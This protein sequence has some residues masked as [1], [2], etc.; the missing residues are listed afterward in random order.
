MAWWGRY[1]LGGE[2]SVG[3]SGERNVVR[4]GI[5]NAVF[6]VVCVC[7]DGG[8]ME[9]GVTELECSCSVKTAAGRL[10]CCA[11]AEWRQMSSKRV[12]R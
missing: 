5:D 11:C 10:L 6:V 4:Q 9:R 8:V 7:V 3:R 12:L 2:R 1:V